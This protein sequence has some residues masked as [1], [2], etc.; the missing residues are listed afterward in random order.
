LPMNNYNVVLPELSFDWD[1]KKAILNQKK[2]RISFSEARTAFADENALLI[3]DPDHSDEEDRF[4]LMGL[5]LKLRIVVVSHGYRK[6]ENVIRIISARKATR[7]E[8]GQYW[9]RCY[10]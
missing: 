4:V 3:Y 2:H 1:D 7:R 9:Q 6:A 5:S 8:E 10:G